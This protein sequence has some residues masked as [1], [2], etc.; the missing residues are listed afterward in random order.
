MTQGRS[1]ARHPAA[2][3]NEFVRGAS[4]P[5]RDDGA[6]LH[7]G[8]EAAL[9]AFAAAALGLVRGEPV[10]RSL[11]AVVR[12]VAHAAG[13][14]VVIARLP[15]EDGERLLARAVYA[16]SAALA[17]ELEGTSLP[18]AAVRHVEAEYILA[19]GD[20]AAPAGI[21]RAAARAGVS[22]VRV[23]PVVVGD[24]VVATFELFG[25]GSFGLREQALAR[26]AAAHVA[27]AVRLERVANEGSD[28]RAEL[29]QASLELLGETLAAG[30]DETETAEHV[31]HLAAEATGAAAATL[32]RLEAEAP[33]TLLAWHGPAGR[34]SDLAEAGEGVRRAL[35]DRNGEPQRTGSWLLHT[36]AL[37]EP[38][39]AA[40]QLAFDEDAVQEPD[41]ERLSPFAAR[42]A[43][44]LRRSRRVGLVALALRRSQTLVA[45]VSQAIAR[46]SLA[47]T[48]ETAVER[49]AELTSS[50]H[51]AVYLREGERLSAAAER[52]LAGPHTD[53]A[54]R[55][56]E[57]ALGPFRSRGFLF[58]EDMR[59]DP[60]LSGLEPVLDESGIRRALFIPLIV[61]DD[62]IGALAVFK[63]RAKPYREGEEGLLVALS[64]QLAVAVQNARLHERT[65]ELGGILERTLE[66]ERRAA[67]QLRGLY[68]ISHSFAESLSLQATLDAVAK[69]MVQLF[70]LDA[71]AIRMPDERGTALETRAIYVADGKIRAAA[72]T[73][74]SRPQPLS[75]PLARRVI[76][77]KRAVLLRPGRPRVADMLGLLEPFLQQGSTAAVLPLATPGE[78]LGT[79][80]LLSLDP[81]RPLAQDT[82]DAA[83]TV[84]AQAALAIDNA[85]LYQQQKDFSET[86][87]RSLLPRVLPAV[88]GLEVGHVYQSAARVDVGGDVYDFLSLDEGRLAVVI[89]D[90][91]GKGIQAAADMAMAKFSFRALARS[92]PEPSDFLRN[93]N[94]VVVEEIEQGKFITMFYVLVD[95]ASGEVAC[96]SAGHPAMRVVMPDGRV[97]QLD[98]P[99]LALGIEPGQ[100]Y[101][102]QAR[103]L[104]PGSSV[105][106]FTDGVVEARRNGELYG[107][108]RLDRLLAARGHLGAQRLAEAILADCR[109]FGGG[110]LADDCAIVVLKLAP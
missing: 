2:R 67:R 93:A 1:R 90:V 7:P 109:A 18:A 14:Q 40:L 60:R 47:H 26:A 66:S 107:E 69:T 87:Q 11:G 76:R 86:M 94:E 99:G 21:R 85:R 12:A 38:P 35:A 37:G 82:V 45:V 36:L 59:R 105:V 17:A 110:D 58:I 62:V 71:A 75:G 92:H 63:T 49:V 29:T 65:K 4:A 5:A 83:L 33:P 41:L 95:P 34:P 96:A 91:L 84:T 103:R 15:A 70:D 80:T 106:L 57:L 54:E 46:L 72:E 16:E 74:L 51:V 89:G 22:V 78:V 88:P 64:S 31:V 77:S 68:E 27:L 81:T 10:E 39:V 24:A 102:A 25:S 104:E 56:L 101:P 73:I 28:G 20:P 30:A 61:H 19:Q 50:G 8:D 9:E 100:E 23:V 79:L 97:T 52:G 3:D 44:A 108:E 32:W 48:L 13:A 98:A 55:L 53:L 43:L 42:A 6:A